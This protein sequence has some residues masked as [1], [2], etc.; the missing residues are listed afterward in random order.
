MHISIVL[1]IFSHFDSDANFFENFYVLKKR[2]FHY[3]KCQIFSTFKNF[4]KYQSRIDLQIFFMFFSSFSLQIFVRFYDCRVRYEF[5][6]STN[7]LSKSR[8]LSIDE[9]KKNNKLTT[10]K[11]IKHRSNKQKSIISMFLINQKI[12]RQ[13]QIRYIFIFM[14]IFKCFFLSFL[15]YLQ[16]KFTMHK[17]LNRVKNIFRNCCS[18]LLNCNK[19]TKYNVK[20][21]H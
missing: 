20:N 11:T 14:L 5:N 17:K 16:S 21:V 1:I 8:I 3:I 7:K 2:S 9:R 18:I 12:S 10:L 19:I 15:H 4:R 13:F 6:I